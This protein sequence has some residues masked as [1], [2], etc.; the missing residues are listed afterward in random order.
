MPRMRRIPPG[1]LSL[2]AD[3]VSDEDRDEMAIPS[4]QHRN[5]LLCWMAWR[6]LEVVVKFF[7]EFCGRTNDASA[8]TVMDFGC[9]TGGTLPVSLPTESLLYRFGRRLAGFGGHYYQSNAA[10]IHQQILDAGFE[11]LRMQRIPAPGPLAIHWVIE[12]P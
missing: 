6:R 1:L 2:M 10:A 3:C 7:R 8:H 11:Q 12:Y 9:G 4:Y 5:P